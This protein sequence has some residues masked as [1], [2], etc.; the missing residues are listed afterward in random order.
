MRPHLL[1]LMLFALSGCASRP[2]LDFWTFQA[3]CALA[4]PNLADEKQIV[5]LRVMVADDRLNKSYLDNYRLYVEYADAVTRSQKEGSI[6]AAQG[7]MALIDLKARL[8][9][10]EQSDR[11][12]RRALALSLALE[13]DD[14]RPTN[15]SISC[16]KVG[17]FVNCSAQ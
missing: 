1:I 11:N 15:L 2:D 7:A 8:V 9:Q 6:T 4:F 16:N 14:Y 5:C 10:T 3:A 17:S 13:G 12:A